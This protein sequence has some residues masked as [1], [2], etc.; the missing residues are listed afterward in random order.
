V[1]SRRIKLSDSVIAREIDGRAVLINLDS[2]FYYSLNEVGCIVFNL[3]LKHGDFDE[4]LEEIEGRFE[5][6]ESEAREDLEAFIG[7]L[8]HERIVSSHS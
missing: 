6:A 7:S 4:I 2:G 5:V 3:I 8:E 1:D